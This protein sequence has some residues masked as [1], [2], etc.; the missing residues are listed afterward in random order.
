MKT[1]ESDIWKY[2]RHI[3]VWRRVSSWGRRESETHWRVGKVAKVFFGG[4]SIVEEVATKNNGE[5]ILVN[6]DQQPWGSQRSGRSHM[7]LALCYS[8]IVKPF[9]TLDF[10]EDSRSSTRSWRCWIFEGIQSWDRTW[11]FWFNSNRVSKCGCRTV[12]T[13]IKQCSLKDLVRP[14][15]I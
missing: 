9:F 3:H 1:K 11:S 12:R 15:R 8:Q 4:E 6:V 13:L 10:E 7:W 5:K 14:D 2:N